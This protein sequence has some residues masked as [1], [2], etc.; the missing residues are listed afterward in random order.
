G[1]ELSKIV[2]HDEN[3][4]Q[5]EEFK[6][7][8]G[9]VVLKRVWIAGTERTGTH[10]FASTAYLY[11]FKGRL[12][13]VVQPNGYE[14]LKVNNWLITKEILN[15]GCFLYDYNEKDE[16]E[17][18]KIPGAGWSYMVY[19]LRGRLVLSQDA[20]MYGRGLW[21]YTLYDN[22]NR[23]IETGLTESGN[24]YEGWQT[25]YNAGGSL[26]TTGSIRHWL[27]KAAYGNYQTVV[28]TYNSD[29]PADAGYFANDSYQYPS[30]PSKMVLD[31]VT[32]TAT[33]V[34][35]SPDDL[36]GEYSETTDYYND[37]GILLQSWKKYADGV[38]DV[39][40]N[41]VHDFNG[42]LAHNYFIH[43]VPTGGAKNSVA[44]ETILT[45]DVYGRLTK[46]E[47][48]VNNFSDRKLIS[49]LQYNDVGQL[50]IKKLGTNPADGLPL[51]IQDFSYNV[52]GW[53]KGIN[54]GS[55]TSNP[56]W[57]KQELLYDVGF[58][59][60][61]LNGNIAGIKWQTKGDGVERAY[62][63]SYDGA[64]R[65]LAADFRQLEGGQWNNTTIN[66]D[67]AYSFDKNGNIGTMKQNGFKLDGSFLMDDMAYNYQNSISNQLNGVMDNAPDK[68]LSDFTDDAAHSNDDYKYDDNGNMFWDGNKKLTVLKYNH[69]NLPQLIE[70]EDKGTIEY[71]Y[72]AAGTKLQ[73]KVTQLDG[74]SKAT[75]YY[76]GFVYEFESTREGLSLAPDI[77]RLQFGAHEEGRMR[78]LTKDPWG[79]PEDW[80][81][82]YFLK[83]HLGNVRMM[84]TDEEK[85]DR[86]PAATLEDLANI[87]D[88]QNPDNYTLF[89][90]R[91]NYVQ[92]PALRTHVNT[93]SGY[94][95]PHAYLQNQYV[96]KLSSSGQ[97]LG[98]GITLKVMSG[99]RLNVRV[100]SWYT[101]N[102]SFPSQ[103]SGSIFTELVNAI[104]AGIGNIAGVKTTA[105]EL[106]GSGVFNQAAL[107]S[108]LQPL[109]TDCGGVPEAY[110]NWIL[111]DEQFHFVA[112]SSGRDQVK[113]EYV[114]STSNPELG[115]YWHQFENLAVDKSGY[116][117]V[118]VS[119]ETPNIDVFFDDLQVTH[120]RGPLLEET[121]YYPFG[122][123]MQ[124]ISS[125]AAGGTENKKKYNGIEFENDLEINTYDA[126]Y[127]ELDPQ[128]ARWWQTDSKTEKMEVWSPY[129]SN[130]DNPLKYSDQ[131]GD[132]GEEC[133]KGLKKL[134]ASVS[135]A[136]LGT[137]DNNIPGS[138]LA[139]AI[140]KSGI[141]QDPD[142]ADAW[143][144][145]VTAS[146]VAGMIQGAGE[147]TAGSALATT[148]LAA[149]AGTGGLSSEVTV[150]TA[151]LGA[152][153]TVHGAFVLN[154]SAQNLASG[155]GLINDRVNSST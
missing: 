143:N 74:S 93:V 120:V 124:G 133:C 68:Q 136:V 9:K 89:Y 153:M 44:V 98:P 59:H 50:T 70:V 47:K 115:L 31:K 4:G 66:Y 155:R 18:K 3:G 105:A 125:K 96:A 25:I 26:I 49:H 80:G 11:D 1:G 88:T 72:D 116:L 75:A 117:Y 113:C 15:A 69:L 84:L 94:P 16:M 24:S 28:R 53:L 123:T 112:S 132:E 54:A 144:G 92:T 148:S 37:Q 85:I 86:Y 48:S 17:A 61:Q 103:P 58:T 101:K 121:H 22:L 39:S 104:S 99:D 32:Y 19:D 13:I 62:G 102:G 2:I 27:T 79:G 46:T 100:S 56:A 65:L 71:V 73:K 7:N 43:N 45:Y 119:N 41:H 87:A 90:D 34:L 149:T 128:T 114:Y 154:K 55:I 12:R 106:R 108:F 118:Y 111:F 142:V 23:S 77:E 38:E 97:K 91:T 129:A 60:N 33:K 110:L 152:G 150:P 29:Y 30:S 14:Q 135:G 6:D 126:F 130:Y 40:I 35:K 64:N 5:T 140:S 76:G 52:R 138:N 151:A 78:R 139:D 82:D 141:I 63:F 122:L 134:F 20:N 21:A 107:Q 42:R 147:S 109:T 8:T 127:R 81:F 67:A 36:A 83:D 95:Q 51:E 10:N 146:N 57:F 137:I 145:G 131:L